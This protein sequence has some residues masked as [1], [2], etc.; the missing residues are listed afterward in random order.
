ML[1]AALTCL[2]IVFVFGVVVC[3]IDVYARLAAHRQEHADQRHAERT[4]GDHLAR[5][6]RRIESLE[7]TR[8]NQ[9]EFWSSDR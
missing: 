4:T 8:L 5:L 6:N 7:R 1:S 2:G 9:R 3:F